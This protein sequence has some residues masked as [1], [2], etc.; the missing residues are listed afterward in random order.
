MD[1]SPAIGIEIS[2]LDLYI[3]SS[4]GAGPAL[5]KIDSGSMASAAS[6]F[7]N[8]RHWVVGNQARQQSVQLPHLCVDGFWETVSMDTVDVGGRKPPRAELANLH[9]EAVLRQS[10]VSSGRVVV[11]VPGTFRGVVGLLSGLADDNGLHCVAL[12]DAAIASLLSAPAAGLNAEHVVVVDVS[13]RSTS[14]TLLDLRDGIERRH[15]RLLE[16]TGWE[17]FHRG[18]VRWL[19]NESVRRTRYD[20]LHDA[21]GEQD[22]VNQLYAVLQTPDDGSPESVDFTGPGAMTVARADFEEHC[23]EGVAAIAEGMQGL[24]DGVSGKVP[25]LLSHRAASVPGIAAALKT[26]PVSTHHSL[27]PGSSALG[28]A[29]F[30]SLLDQMGEDIAE[31]RFITRLGKRFL[32]PDGDQ[33][34]A[35]EEEMAVDEAN[36]DAQEADRAAAGEASADNQ[37]AVEGS[38][39]V[40][41][42]LVFG[43]VVPLRQPKSVIGRDA[44]ADIV[45]AGDCAGV[46]RR[47]CEVVW[48]D[49][50]WLVSDVSRHGLWLDGE[51][52]QQPQVL[53][54]GTILSLGSDQVQLM[55][56]RVRE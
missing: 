18:L 42:L 40:T 9:L 56:V 34:Q 19:R 31:C 53:H 6:A 13:L 41:H 37:P 48:Q 44:D 54:V 23:R 20:P 35:E 3:G 5:L 28:A 45:V 4:R 14:L 10:G 49:G 43:E 22:L 17:Q 15:V 1:S 47:H 7:L 26:L 11:A 21:S 25:V 27:E 38:Q 8:G 55:A 33:Q 16:K 52:L 2:D 24:L 46:S 32:V 36:G 39:E 30:L 50:K 12:L 51:R 29:E